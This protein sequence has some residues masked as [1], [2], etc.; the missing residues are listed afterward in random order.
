M[1]TVH[2]GARGRLEDRLAELESALFELT[3]FVNGASTLSVQAIGNVRAVCEL[4]LAGRYRLEVVDVHRD[5]ALMTSHDVLAV[6]TLI[7]Q[8]PLPKRRIVGDLSDG[9]RVLA[10]LGI[11]AASSVRERESG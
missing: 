5:A 8:S 1:S 6:P 4:H 11:R 10:V 7:R 3:L 2:E 9:P